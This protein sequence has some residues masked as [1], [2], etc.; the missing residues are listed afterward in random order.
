MSP[1]ADAV[2]TRVGPPGDDR[3]G[4]GGQRRPGG[5]RRAAGWLIS[6]IHGYQLVRSGRPTGCRYL[7]TCSEYAVQA[8]NQFGAVHGGSL[9]VKRLA[10]C[11]PWGGHGVDP[12]P[13]RRPSCKHL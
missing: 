8:I 12:V 7:P 10:R 5:P 6:G 3:A 4:D 9:A 1:V 11:N 13:D 2:I